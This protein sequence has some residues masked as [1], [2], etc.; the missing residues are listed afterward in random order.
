[1]TEAERTAPIENW[2]ILT[3]YASKYKIS[4]STLRR[5]IKADQIRYRFDQGRYLLADETPG[6]IQHAQPTYSAPSTTQVLAHAQAAGQSSPQSLEAELKIKE[7]SQGEEP[8]ISTATRLLNELK[9][10]YTSI[11][12]E[13]E[14]QMILLKEE[15]AD[16][17]TLVRVLESDNNRMRA[18][19]QNIQANNPPQSWGN[20]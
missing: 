8:I 2:L 11:L 15:V 14:E 5:R 12:Q 4:V 17:K 1:M 13:K 16:L 3:D 19:L 18:I 6:D 10:A 7:L 9:R 20:A